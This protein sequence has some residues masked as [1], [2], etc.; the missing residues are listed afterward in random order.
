MTEIGGKY[1]PL[2]R[3]LTWEILSI[4]KVMTLTT[5][6][7]RHCPKP[8]FHYNIIDFKKTLAS[9]SATFRVAK[10][11]EGDLGDVHQ[12]PEQKNMDPQNNGYFHDDPEE[13]TELKGLG[14]TMASNTSSFSSN[15]TTDRDDYDITNASLVMNMDN[16][17]MPN[18]LSSSLSGDDDFYQEITFDDLISIEAR[19]RLTDPGLFS[20]AFGDEVDEGASIN[21]ATSADTGWTEMPKE[22]SLRPLLHMPGVGRNVKPRGRPSSSPVLVEEKMD[23]SSV[24]SLSEAA[25]LYYQSLDLS[26]AQLTRAIANELYREYLMANGFILSEVFLTNGEKKL[27]E[28]PKYSPFRTPYPSPLRN[29]WTVPASYIND[30]DCEGHVAVG[31]EAGNDD[32]EAVCKD[33][34]DSSYTDSDTT[35]QSTSQQSPLH[36]RARSY[37]REAEDQL[38]AEY[39]LQAE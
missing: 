32:W 36:K 3:A 23:T 1:S 6:I 13:S 33:S 14:I 28:T 39:Q 19:T 21:G 38:Q 18:F 11:D 31:E 37:D 7:Y 2:V 27:C 29:C 26:P 34:D 35:T 30:N 24:S 17:E 15:T 4:C 8:R 10:M 16:M 25:R 9:S 5:S 12:H 22:R 20:Q